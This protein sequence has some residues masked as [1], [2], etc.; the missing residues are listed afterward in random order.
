MTES[1]WT[2]D[3][4]SPFKSFKHLRCVENLGIPT[5]PH[6]TENSITIDKFSLH[7]GCHICCQSPVR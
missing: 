6:P 3:H 5:P 2:G 1:K 4:T 7:P